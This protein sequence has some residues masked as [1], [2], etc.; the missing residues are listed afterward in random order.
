M[1]SVRP[2]RN[3]ADATG[4]VPSGGGPYLQSSTDTVFAYVAPMMRQ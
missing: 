4:S 2:P 3:R 1:V